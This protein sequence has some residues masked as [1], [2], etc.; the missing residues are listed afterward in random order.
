[1]AVRTISTKLAVEGEAEY[2]QKI[3]SCNSELK[4]LKSLSVRHR[5]RR[6]C[7]GPFDPIQIVPNHE[8]PAEIPAR[9]RGPSPLGTGCGR[10]A[11]RTAPRAVRTRKVGLADRPDGG[12]RHRRQRLPQPQH[13]AES[14]PELLFG[15]SGGERPHGLCR[16]RR[17]QLRHPPAFRRGE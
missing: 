7:R 14:Q 2:K 6:L 3:A 16:G 13:G 5:Q 17:R 12:R 9:R 1:M 10:R 15:R 8:T 4:T 11:V